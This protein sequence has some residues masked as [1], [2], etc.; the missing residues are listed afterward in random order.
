MKSV[1]F[2]IPS[3]L[4]GSILVCISIAAAFGAD[5][6]TPNST[7]VKKDVESKE[8]VIT[9]ETV[10]DEN[11][12][13]VRLY[14]FDQIPDSAEIREAIAASW[15]S[16]PIDKVIKKTPELHTDSKGNMFTVSGKY[17]EDSKDVYIISII[18]NLTDYSLP[19]HNLVPQGTWMLYRKADTGAPL[20]I[21]IYPRE[22]PAL[23]VSLRP[24]S[25]K[26]YS[27][28]SFIDI[29]L[30]NAYVRKDIAIGVPFETL[31]HIS[32][33]RL[34]ALSQSIIPWDLFNPPRDNSSVKTMSRIVENLRYRL[35]RVKDGC[36]DHNGKPVHISNSQPQTELEITAAM[37]ID[38]IRSEIIGGVDSAGFAKWVIDGIIR[39]IAGQGT[40]VESLKRETDAPKTHFTRPYLD[41]E[42]IFFGL[43]WIRNLGAAALSLNLNRTVYPDSSGLDVNSCPF[44]LTDAAI[45]MGLSAKT[46]AVKQPAF[47]GY[48][49][50]AGY[51]TS[52]LLPLLYYFTIVEPDHF[53]L[54]CISTV[55]S[56]TELR[57]YDRV[58][59]FF[60]YF[61]SLGEFHLDIYEDGE[62]IPV[63][64]FI[65]KNKD[66]YT[67][68][69]RVRAPEKGLF[70]P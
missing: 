65:E 12:K 61:D 36:F 34:K 69:V 54:A 21:K 37:N 16:A 18:P 47:L 31:Y 39:P 35:V 9:V 8:P 58:A 23:S 13:T 1:C 2:R 60:P 17:A 15:F 46:G 29:C 57:M 26:A 59:V 5:A 44:A 49:R 4:I 56:A 68:M 10:A 40:V 67:A 50:Y 41:T 45:P 27:G 11:P 38:Q 32:L 42:N 30:F 28:K 62:L 66:S 22:N 64:E 52:Y 7:A 70:N 20:L 33:L 48:Q 51:Q 63:D 14:P 53:Y 24:A 55:S 25:Q 3:Y 19:E 43:D 6:S